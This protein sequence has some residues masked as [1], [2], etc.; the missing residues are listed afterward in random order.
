[1]KKFLSVLAFAVLSLPAYSA[2]DTYARQA[3]TTNYERHETRTRTRTYSPAQTYTAMSARYDTPVMTGGASRGE[4][5]K[6]YNRTAIPNRSYAADRT[7][8]AR[9]QVKRKYYLSHPFFQPT[10][11]KFGLITDLSYGL[12][13][14]DMDITPLGTMSD[15]LAKWDMKQFAIKEDISYGITDRLGVLLMGRYDSSRYKFDWSIAPDDTADSSGFNV[16]GVG[17]QGRFADTAEW[18]G[19]LSGYYE[20][21]KHL[22]DEYALDLKIGYK[23]SQ[24]TMYGVARGWWVDFKD[25]YYGNGMSGITSDGTVEA[26]F[27]AYNMDAKDIMFFEG[28]LGVFSVLDEDWTLNL[29]GIFGHYDWHNQA[30]L[31]AAFGW[32]PNDW[33]AFN[34]YAKAAI[35]DSAEGKKLDFYGTENGVW[36][37]MGKAELDNYNEMAFGLQT[38]FCF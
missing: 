3:K 10:A 4:M 23:V 17:I 38:I 28:G 13:S 8:V 32:Q 9:T 16:Y 12:A 1:M 26:I 33:F 11:G 35:F 6:S 19:T 18:I 7:G 36:A 14:Y 31:K 5:Y 27:L 2:N 20:R 22:A 37:L 34:V 30:Y 25:E 15:T 21:Q 24:A 29:E